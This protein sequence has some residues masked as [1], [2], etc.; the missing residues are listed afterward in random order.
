M[1][2]LILLF[3]RYLKVL[4]VVTSAVVDSL[5]NFLLPESINANQLT[6]TSNT[7]RRF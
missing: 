6:L 3:K 2:V 7:I 1:E 4:A 5:V